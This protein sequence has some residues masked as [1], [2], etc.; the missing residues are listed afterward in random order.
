VQTPSGFDEGLGIS[1]VEEDHIKNSTMVLLTH[2][3]EDGGVTRSVS[4]MVAQIRNTTR[5][6]SLGAAV[7]KQMCHI[8][9]WWVVVAR[10]WNLFPCRRRHR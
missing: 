9:W 5:K 4:M 2:V 6:K 3:L 7:S 8:D 10:W 1:G